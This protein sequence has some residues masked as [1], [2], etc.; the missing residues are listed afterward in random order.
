M[1]VF[2]GGSGYDANARVAEVNA[3]GAITKVEYN[4]QYGGGGHNY[5]LQ[6]LPA[7]TVNSANILASNAV[8][9][10][11]GILGQGASF[12]AVTDRA[13]SITTINLLEP[14]EDYIATPNVSFKIQDILVSNV[15]L[16]NPPVRGDV[17][18]QGSTITTA[19]YVA[20]VNSISTLTSDANTALSKYN[21]R[22]Y[23]YNGTPNT[24]LQLNIDRNIH[25]TPGNTS[26]PQYVNTFV[27]NGKT[28][29]TQG[30]KFIK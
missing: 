7:V 11:A 14:G 10:V 2:T 24:S 29:N 4:L 27:Y 19:S 8:L 20:T 28:Y 15:S 17:V 9:Q 30:G 6:Y 1:I 26:F 21:L 25:L 13:G 12:S 5:T 23:N 16:S 18:Y 22:V 3:T